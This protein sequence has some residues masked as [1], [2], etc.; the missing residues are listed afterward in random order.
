MDGSRADSLA[1][2]VAASSALTLPGQPRTVLT[3]ISSDCHTWNLVFLQLLLEEH[4]HYVANCGPC[5]PVE[6]A[7]ERCVLERAQLL[8][9]STVNGHG[10]IEAGSYITRIKA[11]SRL[12]G[13]RVVLGGKLGVNGSTSE[14][15]VAQL[16]ALGF[17]AIFAADASSVMEFSNYMRTAGLVTTRRELVSGDAPPGGGLTIRRT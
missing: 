17:D 1:A 8:V 10:L 5:V 12:I 15:E 7:I 4:G 2:A 16:M 3:T 14:A 6:E 13:L 9:I 11:D